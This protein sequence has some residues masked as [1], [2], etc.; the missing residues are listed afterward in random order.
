M[1][2]LDDLDAATINLETSF[3]GIRVV[4][5]G[6]AQR[7]ALAEKERDEAI[8]KNEVSDAERARYDNLVDR[9]IELARKATTITQG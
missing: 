6:L 2:R 7:V 8:A 5:D 4:F 3:E 1:T 9:L